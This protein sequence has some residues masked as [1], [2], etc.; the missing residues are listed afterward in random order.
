MKEAEEAPQ[1]PRKC[2]SLSCPNRPS[3]STRAWV[4][5]APLS[6]PCLIFAPS[7]LCVLRSRV[8]FV[9][10]RR[11]GTVQSVDALHSLVSASLPLHLWSGSF[12]AVPTALPFLRRSP[13]CKSN[14]ELTSEGLQAVPLT[15][16]TLA[17]TSGVCLMPRLI[18]VSSLPPPSLPASSA[19]SLPCSPL[20]APPAPVGKIA[21]LSVDLKRRCRTPF[22][23]TLTDQCVAD[24]RHPPPALPGRVRIRLSAAA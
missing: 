12:Y 16:D 11:A 3:S 20:F 14:A 17:E 21:L 18:P 22:P 15:S 2:S 19:R 23:P 8:L 5:A 13:W 24:T 9:P 4:R 7:P 6:R 1:C 10:H